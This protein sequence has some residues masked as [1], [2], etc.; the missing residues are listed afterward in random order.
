MAVNRAVSSHPPC[1]NGGHFG[2]D[3]PV[4][5]AQLLAAGTQLLLAAVKATPAFRSG[6]PCV[7]PKLKPR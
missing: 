7:V 1:L 4:G 2:T 5:V 6:F 3:S